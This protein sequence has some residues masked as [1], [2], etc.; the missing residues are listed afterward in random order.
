MVSASVP[1]E[2]LMQRNHDA[3]PLIA[4]QSPIP[5]IALPA[6]FDMCSRVIEEFINLTQVTNGPSEYEGDMAY[7]MDELISNFHEL[8]TND[9]PQEF[10]M[11]KREF[12]QTNLPN[13]QHLIEL[14]SRCVDKPERLRRFYSRLLHKVEQAYEHHILGW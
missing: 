14:M 5:Y 9:D 2:K 8:M 7:V 1:V 3:Y 4:E 12:E 6:Y 11:F 13:F 10:Y